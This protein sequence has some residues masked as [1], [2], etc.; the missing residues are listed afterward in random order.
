MQEASRD[1][2]RLSWWMGM[3]TSPTAHEEKFKLQI[4]RGT[5]IEGKVATSLTNPFPSPDVDNPNP[6]ETFVLSVGRK[7]TDTPANSSCPTK[8]KPAIAE[9]YTVEQLHRAFHTLHV[10]H[11]QIR[12]HLDLTQHRLGAEY[13]SEGLPLPFFKDSPRTELVSVTVRFLAMLH[14]TKHKPQL[15]YAL[16]ECC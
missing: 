7:L 1:T 6:M 8:Q 3:S 4:L 12:E 10:E 13:G 9:V 11:I 2:S 15:C 14:K 5:P 16:Q